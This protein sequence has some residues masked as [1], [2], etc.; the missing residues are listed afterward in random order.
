MGTH[1]IVLNESFPM[2]T[3]MAGFRWYS[4]IFA[5]LCLGES[6]H[7]IGRVNQVIGTSLTMSNYDRLIDSISPLLFMNSQSWRGLNIGQKLRNINQL[8]P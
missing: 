4:K 3:N 2:N 5:S 1:L 8:I 6:S 7:S